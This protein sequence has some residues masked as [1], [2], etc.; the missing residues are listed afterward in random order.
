MTK[1]SASLTF[2]LS[3]ETVSI[4]LPHFVRLFRGRTD[5]YALQ[6]DD[7]AY[8]R[9]SEPL[10]EDVLRLHLSGTI[11]V[12]MYLV[13]AGMDCC[14][15]AVIDVDS[16]RKQVAEAMIHAVHSVGLQEDEVL[17][18]ASGNKGIHVWIF[19]DRPQNAIDAIRL[20]QHLCRLAGVTAEVFPK[21]GRVPIGGFGN[22]IKLP[23]RH[24]KSGKYSI[25]FDASFTPLDL[26]ILGRVSALSDGRIRGLLEKIAP[27]ADVQQ[28][29]ISP[30]IDS[31]G[32]PSIPCIERILRGV[33]AGHRNFASFRVAIYLKRQGIPEDMA[34]SAIKAWNEHN[35]PPLPPGELE[36]AL[37]QAFRRQYQ[38]LGCQTTD[39][40]EFCIPDACPIHAARLKRAQRA[41]PEK[42]G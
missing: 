40:K 31:S 30:P 16:K 38:G 4:V 37:R 35:Q 18:E 34:G 28:A 19:F 1:Q 10:S 9:V 2:P 8:R 41:D 15:L 12:G 17:M 7:G 22:P 3:D 33:D 11:T 27:A 42:N 6:R 24:A 20:G 36:A 21:Q 25:F 14:Y 32:R 39:M 26:T 29:T 5:A 23:G 13:D